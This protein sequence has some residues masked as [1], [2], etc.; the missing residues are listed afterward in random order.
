[1]NALQTTPRWK[2]ALADALLLTAHD[3]ATGRPRV[4]SRVLGRGLAAALLCELVLAGQVTLDSTSTIV[5]DD[6]RPPA[7]LQ[8][9]TVL[10]HLVTASTGAPAR[11]WITELGRD[12]TTLVVRRLH[13]A[14]QV[15]RDRVRTGFLHLTTQTVYRVR[16]P[17]TGDWPLMSVQNQLA[18]GEVLPMGQ[19]TFA[20]LV[21][22]IGLRSHMLNGLDRRSGL[23]M[24]D[25]VKLLPPSLRSLVAEAKAAIGDAVMSRR[26]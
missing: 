17:N 10:N 21:D 11:Q 5:V 16:D 9:H 8:L 4:A 23:L 25:S 19:A 15:E 12:S 1:M 13:D 3:S 2:P 24:Q 14:G 26:G 22:A 7:D 6:P 18:R 20:G